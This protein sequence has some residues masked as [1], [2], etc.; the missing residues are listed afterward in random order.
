[1]TAIQYSIFLPVRNG[2]AYIK[3]CVASILDQDYHDFELHILDNCSTDG[4]ADWVETVTDPRVRLWR[5]DRPLSMVESWARIKDVPKREFMTT[6]GHDDLFDRGF[7][8][9]MT[10]LIQRNPEASL[11]QTGARYINAH[12][13]SIRSCKPIPVRETAPQFFAAQLQYSR[14]VFGTGYVMRSTDYERLGGIPPF[15]RLLFA[16]NA[17]W[18][19]LARQSWKAADPRVAISI[20][21]HNQSESASMPSL[22]PS[23]LKGLEQFVDF[24]DGYLREDTAARAVFE[25]SGPAFMLRYHRS[26]YIYALLEACQQR[27]TIAPE[28]QPQIWASLRKGAPAV[29]EQLTSST[30]IKILQLFNRSPFRTVIPILW[31]IYQGIRTRSF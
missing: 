20:R 4:T 17:L 27:R 22:W 12:G 11:F 24:L 6:I 19:L 28:V 14:D 30:T 5:S 7:L 1:M 2:G 26:L 18:M 31:K 8:A 16:D 15:E 21:I 9:I 10:D 25:E 3:D 13:K 23:F 29:A